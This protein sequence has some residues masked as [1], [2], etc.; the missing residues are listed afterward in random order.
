MKIKV[1]LV[2]S[3]FSTDLQ[4][5]LLSD[6]CSPA[7]RRPNLRNRSSR[8]RPGAPE[9]SAEIQTSD[10]Q[11]LRLYMELAMKENTIIISH[12]PGVPEYS[13]TGNKRK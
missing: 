1:H 4:C 6:C 12:R 2:P 3:L 5:P 9:Y 10:I 7:P 11:T 13:G 8:H